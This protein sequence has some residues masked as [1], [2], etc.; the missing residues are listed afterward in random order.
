MNESIFG[1]WSHHT[2]YL[3][4]STLLPFKILVSDNDIVFNLV[5]NNVALPDTAPEV[6]QAQEVEQIPLPP[7]PVVPPVAVQNIPN[8]H[9]VA[10]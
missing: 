3:C 10:G 2:W 7:E 1:F 4:R 6:D 8:Q 5:G 9:Q